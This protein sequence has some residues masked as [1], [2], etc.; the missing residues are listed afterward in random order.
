MPHAL[1]VCVPVN[2]SCEWMFCLFEIKRCLLIDVMV[3]QMLCCKIARINIK[4]KEESKVCIDT[5][6]ASVGDF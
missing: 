3:V 4:V 5:L 1:K 2:Y 6:P